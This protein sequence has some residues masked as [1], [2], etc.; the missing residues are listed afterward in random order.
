MSPAAG[1]LRAVGRWFIIG[2]TALAVWL[3]AQIFVGL[4]FGAV[5]RFFDCSMEILFGLWSLVAMGVTSLAIAVF[6]GMVLGNKLAAWVM[7]QT[8]FTD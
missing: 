7:S 4:V 2:A 1:L 8:R 6:L 3:P 5:C